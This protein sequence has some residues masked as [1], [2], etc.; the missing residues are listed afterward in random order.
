MRST[1]TPKREAMSDE[2]AVVSIGQ[3]AALL[4]QMPHRI[5]V[6][7]DAL[8]VT[9]TMRINTIDYFAESD[10]QRIGDHLRSKGTAKQ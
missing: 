6:A 2:R 10:I 1:L 9:P 8:G 7:A 5:R 4:Q 3:A